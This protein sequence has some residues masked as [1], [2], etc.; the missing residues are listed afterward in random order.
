MQDPF[1]FRRDKQPNKHVVN[2]PIGEL[3]IRLWK[4]LVSNAGISPRTVWTTLSRD[5]EATLQFMGFGGDFHYEHAR[6]RLM[7]QYG[8]R[9][10]LVPRN[11]ISANRGGFDLQT[12]LRYVSEVNDA[13]L[14]ALEN[15]WHKIYIG[16][17]SVVGQLKVRQRE[18]ESTSALSATQTPGDISKASISTST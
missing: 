10:T 9:A 8:T 2:S 7:M 4:N 6:G 1:R 16:W 14:R 3:P 17:H 18:V 5:N 12:A 11:D 15:H 13:A